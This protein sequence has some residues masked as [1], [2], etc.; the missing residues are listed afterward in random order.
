VRLATATGRLCCSTS[1][2]AT[3]EF[4]YL[5]FSLSLICVL[6]AVDSPPPNCPVGELVRLPQP[7]L[8]DSSFVFLLVWRR[9]SSLIRILCA[10]CLPPFIFF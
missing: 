5:W 8:L 4:W 10:G 6:L 9:Y 3:E 7:V 2:L 1:P